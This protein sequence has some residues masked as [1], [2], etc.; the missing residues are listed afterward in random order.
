M[1]DCFVFKIKS[2][3]KLVEVHQLLEVGL[4]KL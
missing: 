2:S 3:E 4:R 1:R